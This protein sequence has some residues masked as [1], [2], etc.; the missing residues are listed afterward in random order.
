MLTPLEDRIILAQH[1]NKPVPPNIRP[2]SDRKHQCIV[3]TH[4][5]D[6]IM[7][8]CLKYSF[9]VDY[10]EVCDSFIS[11]NEKWRAGWNEPYLT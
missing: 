3:C 2:S 6:E 8:V 4:C 10:E 5:D 11:Y 1:K 9:V 7:T